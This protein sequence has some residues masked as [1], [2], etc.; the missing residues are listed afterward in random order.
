MLGCATAVALNNAA[1]CNTVTHPLLTHEEKTPAYFYGLF[2]LL[3]ADVASGFR[4]TREL[5]VAIVHLF[6]GYGGG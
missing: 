3:L 5:G 6:K 4:N 2:F 1:V